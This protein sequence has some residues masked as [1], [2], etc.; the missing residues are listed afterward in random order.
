MGREVAQGQGKNGECAMSRLAKWF[1][2]VTH[3]CKPLKFDESGDVIIFVWE[4]PWCF[5]QKFT[6][7]AECHK[8]KV[9]TKIVADNRSMM[10]GYRKEVNGAAWSGKYDYA[11]KD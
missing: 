11:I 3:K 1:R 4:V 8:V 7:C 6:V 9:L 10:G 5:L 2:K